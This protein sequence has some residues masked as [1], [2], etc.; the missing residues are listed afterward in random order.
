MSKTE[1]E[2]QAL[3]FLEILCIKMCNKNAK[4]FVI[5]L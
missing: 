3:K 5:T 1:K 4:K 2:E